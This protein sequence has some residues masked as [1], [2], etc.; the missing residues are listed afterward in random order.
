MQARGGGGWLGGRERSPAC[1]RGV[2]R[3]VGRGF[4]GSAG[5]AA[6]QRFCS[7]SLAQ[8][9]RAAVARAGAGGSFIATRIVR[10]AYSLCSVAGNGFRRCAARGT[11]PQSGVHRPHSAPHAAAAAAG[12][13]SAQLPQGC[14]N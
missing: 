8:H 4:G 9:P 2:G 5:G 1:R 3:G 11:Q 10:D 6:A 12:V 7:S 14:G 13:P